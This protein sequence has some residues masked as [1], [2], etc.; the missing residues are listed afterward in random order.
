MSINDA[1]LRAFAKTLRKSLFVPDWKEY[2]SPTANDPASYDFI[3][4]FYEMTMITAQNGGFIYADDRG[5]AQKWSKDGSGAKAMVEKMAEI[6]AA[7]AL[8]FYDLAP[9]EAEDKIAPLLEGVPFAQKRLKIFKEFADPENHEK[10]VAL[11]AS[12]CDGETYRLD[13]DFVKN[14]AAIFPEGLGNDP[15]FKKATLTVLMAAGNAHHHG[16]KVDVSDLT[17]AADYV[18]PQVL[19]AGDVG[20]LSFSADLAKDL[21][22]RKLFDEDNDR[23]AALRAAAVVVCERLA[24]LSGLSAQD[25]DAALWLAGR[26]IKSTENKKVLPHM[27]CKT[28]RF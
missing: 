9:D 24:E 12:A 27:M 3:R 26:K 25:I 7:K 5:R 17:I 28:M 14:L 22:D 10:A 16:V 19:N 13:M 15:F 4:A 18:L 23:V 2:I 20:I 11:L 21:E 6:R 1:T 8:P